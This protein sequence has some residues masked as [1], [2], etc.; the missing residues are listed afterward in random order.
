MTCP[1]PQIVTGG[2]N[3]SGRRNRTQ[4]FLR[5]DDDVS[6][7]SDSGCREPF[8]EGN[9]NRITGESGQAGNGAAL[10]GAMGAS[11]IRDG[12]SAWTMPWETS[13]HRKPSHSLL[14][15]CRIRHLRPNQVL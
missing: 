11:G 2:L 8:P 6:P 9:G 4:G 3:A 1:V 14:L 13:V 10:L 15:I 5:M 12:G 7:L